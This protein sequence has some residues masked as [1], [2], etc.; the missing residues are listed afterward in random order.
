MPEFGKENAPDLCRGVALLGDASGLDDSAVFYLDWIEERH[1]LA[2]LGA[3]LLDAVRS[4]FLAD[5]CELLAAGLVLLDELLREGSV[6]NVV[7]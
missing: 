6:L 2:E 1:G 4:L 5:A 7:E 3:N